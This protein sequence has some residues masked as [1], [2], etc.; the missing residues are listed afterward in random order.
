MPPTTH[1][2]VQTVTYKGHTLTWEEHNPGD[3]TFIVIAGHGNVRPMWLPMI[4]QLRDLGRWVSLDLVGHY[5]ATTP[6]DFAHLKQATLLDV[7]QHAIEQIADG[8]PVTLMGHSTGGLV[9]LGVAAR[10]PQQVQRVISISSIIWGPP[11][12]FL[13]LLESFLRHR[14]WPA[15]WLVGKWM[16]LTPLNLVLGA[17]FYAYHRRAFLHNP[18]T[19]RIYGATHAWFRQHSLRNLAIVLHM[20]ETCDIRPLI[21]TLPTPVLAITGMCDPIVSPHQTLWLSNTLPCVTPCLLDYIGHVLYIEAPDAMV[22]CIRG[23]V[24]CHPC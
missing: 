1:N 20:L 21:A 9:A 18:L 8:R 2:T 22:R 12:G 23:W 10:L 14:L 4:M 16:Q 17:T 6:P 7:Q 19:W 15:F 11:T 5:P 3:H 13:Q 24:A